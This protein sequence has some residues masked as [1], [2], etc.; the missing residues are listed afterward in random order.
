[1]K[2]NLALTAFL[3]ILCG[4]ILQAQVVINEFSCSNLHFFQNGFGDY[5]DYIEL[6]NNSSNPVD[7]GGHY[8]S[9]RF[10]NPMKWQIPAGTTIQPFG[11]MVFIC[12]AKLPNEQWD[13]TYYHTNFRLTQ[14]YQ[15]DVVFCD[16][17]GTIIDHYWMEHPTQMNHSRGR[18]TDGGPE[19]GIMVNPTPGAPNTN[20]YDDYTLKP[21]I[22]LEAGFYEGPQTVTISTPEPDV[23]IRY[24][25]NG[26]KPDATSPIYTGPLTIA[27]TTTVRAR[28]FPV[29]GSG[30]GPT[31]FCDQN[32]GAGNQGFPSNPGC[33]SAICG[34]DPFCCNN[35]WDGICGTAAI[36]T[37]ACLLC[38]SPA[39]AVYCDEAQGNAG[40]PMHPACQTA[41]CGADAFCCNNQWDG[42]CANAAATH[43][44]C[45]ECSS[46]YDPGFGGGGGDA[47]LFP[48]F[49][50]TNTYFI[51]ETFTFRTVSLSGQLGQWNAGGGGGWVNVNGN[52]HNHYE[53]CLE[54]FDE[55]GTFI[56]EQEGT[57]RRHGNDS[58]AYAQRGLRFHSR[59]QQ[60][61]S[62]SIY[63]PL[64]SMKDRPNYDVIIM[65]AGGSD[66]YP[67]FPGLPTV[68]FRDG[69]GQTAAQL[70]NTELDAR[71]FE[72]QI[73]FLNGQYW[74]VY[75][76]RERVDKDYTEYYY[77]QEE[78]FVDL[79]KY[80][81]G[82]E[83]QY[84]SSAAW[85]ALHNFITTNDMSNQINYD[86]VTTQLNPESFIDNF[87]VNTYFVNTD[88][89]NWN[90]MWWRGT[91]GAGER[92]RYALWDIDNI[93]NLGQNYTGWSG[94]GPYVNTV[95]EAQ[96]MFL[97]WS[98]ANGHTAMYAAMLDNEGFFTQYLNRYADL[99]NTG[100]HCDTL[101][102]LL[103]EFEANMLPEMPR[104]I[105]RWGGNITQWQ[106]RIQDVRDFICLRWEIVMQQII[107]CFE[108]DYDISGPYDVT[109][110]II[111][112]GNVQLNT[113]TITVGPW[114]G[115]YF[116]G[117]DMGLTAMP[118]PDSEFIQWEINNNFV[119]QNLLDHNL[120]LT[121]NSSDTIFAY[122]EWI[123]NPLP[124]EW[125][126]FDGKVI[127]QHGELYWS[128][129]TEVN[130]SHF[131]VQRS[132][133][134]RNFITI[135]TVNAAGNSVVQSSYQFTDRDELQ[136]VHYYRIKQVDFDGSYDY[137]N[138]IALDYG[139]NAGSLLVAP[140]PNNGV[141][142][143]VNRSDQVLDLNLLT[144][145]GQ[146]L[147]TLTL[148][149]YENKQVNIKN[150][151][152]GIYM[153]RYHQ[154]GRLHYQKVAVN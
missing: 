117:L 141:F 94:T 53:V 40:F 65:R 100:L 150:G 14:T 73:T 71:T 96:N 68:H 91:Q 82:L 66:N 95:C 112:P 19:W 108:D 93:F 6:Y 119:G 64:F 47:N 110:V 25:T 10:T 85:F 20:V 77:G 81:G 129:A 16:P 42:I 151:S 131:V 11:F 87:I 69:F 152:S 76:L 2:T 15:E 106:N 63:H 122:F 134:A 142:Q 103:D 34:A 46:N 104:Q 74:G 116:G 9:D 33:E 13:G 61:F 115:T 78:R 39:N 143:L 145:L 36:T 83:E 62:N 111:G 139:L 102:A 126:S 75:E 52:W 114:T 153:L 92:W 109:V 37:P 86:Y 144:P 124:V 12:S 58:W 120:L 125:L 140:N 130:N 99:L 107:D 41:I 88:W 118:L 54:Y 31:V 90:V 22:S 28:A 60:G 38:L 80:W 21:L 32:Q 98:A 127:D 146:D 35:Q 43:P 4:C 128:T 3:H 27:A 101:V 67:A 7:I 24:T 147:L 79:M 18:K 49:T 1:M 59:D 30:G 135:G 89:L 97:N 148:Q 72:H 29:G 133:D 50:E 8:L 132:E 149:P 57:L 84:G 105:Q 70:A 55:N 121:L 51:D 113:V 123:D 45:V 44:A 26:T 56:T 17:M 23:V 48:G 137:S 138:T 154:N 136:G 5:N